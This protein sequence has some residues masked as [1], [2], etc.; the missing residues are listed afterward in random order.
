MIYRRF[1]RPLLFLLDAERAHRIGMIGLS[2]IGETP[3]LRGAVRSTY[4][5]ND[6]LLRTRVMGLDLPNPLGIAAG[7]DKNGEAFQGLGCLGAGFVEIGTVTPRPQEGNPKPRLFRLS[8]DKAL[9][10]RMGFNNDG[11]EIISER[12]QNRGKG[13]IIGANIGKNK[14][15]P[16]DR[17]AD[18]YR[19]CLEHLHP[20]VDYLVI[21]LSSPNTPGVRELQEKDALREVLGQSLDQRERFKDPKPVLLKISPDLGDGALEDILRIV[22]EMGVDGL[23]ATNTSV[24]RDGLLSDRERADRTG[25][26]GIS[27]APLLGRSDR[28]IRYLKEGTDRKIPIIGVG[29]IMSE[30]DAIRKLDAGADL[31]QVYTGLIY[32]GPSLLK[33]ILKAI[34]VHRW[35]E[36]KTRS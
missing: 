13:P 27:G 16:Q 11:V 32:E 15:T 8:K 12:L 17:S 35:N 1:L 6:E 3:F 2:G 31:L 36:K 20:F 7:L 26:G 21:N 9:L 19:S 29:G 14:D 23:V 28:V 25:T 24:D 33:R 18:D 10:N 22:Q 4:T 34:T 5:L 30:S